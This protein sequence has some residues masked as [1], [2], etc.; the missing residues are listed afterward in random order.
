MSV[1]FLLGKHTDIYSRVIK[2]S[3]GASNHVTR[4]PLPQPTF[5][6]DNFTLCIAILHQF[7]YK[8][9]TTEMSSTN[10]E[11]KGN[12]IP[13]HLNIGAIKILLRIPSVLFFG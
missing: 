7:H 6:S 4:Y 11:L 13:K 2:Y 3:L 8:F 9:Y 1:H 12:I 10:N 5:S